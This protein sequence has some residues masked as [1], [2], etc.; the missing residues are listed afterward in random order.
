[1][2]GREYVID[3][4]ILALQTK[5]KRELEFKSFQAYVTDA[6][7][8]IAENTTHH[9]GMSGVVD[10]GRSFSKRWY[11]II[12]GIPKGESEEKPKEEP[13]DTRTAEEFASDMWARIKGK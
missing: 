6:L 5:N 1:M 11:E 3:H 8:A 4:S 7:M 2:V 10:C 12:E 9:I 13:K